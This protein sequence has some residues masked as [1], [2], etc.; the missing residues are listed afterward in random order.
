M[1]WKKI[2]GAASLSFIVM[3]TT[4]MPMH[5]D[6]I[7]SAGPQNLEEAMNSTAANT[8]IMD[9]YAMTLIK[10]PNFALSEIES[11]D[12]VDLNK[13]L[14][15][16]LNLAR[17][18]ANEWLDDIKPHL[19]QT[20]QNIIGY[21]TK[22]QNYFGTIKQRLETGD[23]QT[24]AL[25]LTLLR[26]DVVEN[27]EEV[28]DVIT[29]L[30]NFRQELSTDSQNFSQDAAQIT[31]ILSGD[32]A[33]ITSIENEIN[34]VNQAID[35]D[36]GIIAGGAVGQLVGVAIITAGVLSIWAGGAGAKLIVGGTV[37]LGGAT[38]AVALAAQDLEEKKDALKNLT[39]QL[40]GLR[41]EVAA[42]TLTENQVRDLKDQ[43]DGAITALETL[44]LQWTVMDTKYATLIDHV[45][46]IEPG[47]GIFVIADLETAK[48]SWQDI[49]DLAQ[50]LYL[51]IGYAEE[52]I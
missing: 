17:G 46:D 6:D 43:I 4:A 26:G 27:K 40:T 50:T 18:H 11:S 24:A 33:L 20:N 32:D 51:D 1:N 45:E 29:I 35:R 47:G 19:V 42:L 16:H 36:I 41:A 52:D 14:A 22:Y 3:F 21:N 13:S 12:K 10:Q 34:A 38:T 7:G 15:Q 25:G 44:K 48:D 8:L 37:I 9:T 31:A 49:S 23:S 28:E 5:A 2:L 30:K 39:Q